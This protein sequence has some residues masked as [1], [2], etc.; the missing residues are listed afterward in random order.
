[1]QDSNFNIGCNIKILL[2]DYGKKKKSV[3]LITN[4]NSNYCLS[5][6]K[7]RNFYKRNINFHSL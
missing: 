6:H 3:R 1:M 4:N 2:L 7:L 5:H